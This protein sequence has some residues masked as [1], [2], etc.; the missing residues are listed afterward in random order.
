VCCSSAL[1]PPSCC[2]HESSPLHVP[3]RSLFKPRHATPR[4]E[5]I[6][7]S[8]V[9]SPIE[10]EDKILR[11]VGKLVHTDVDLAFYHLPSLPPSLP[12]CTC[13][14]GAHRAN[15]RDRRGID[16]RQESSLDSIESKSRLP[17]RERERSEER[18]GEDRKGGE[19]RG[20][21]LSNI[22]LRV[23]EPH[24]VDPKN[25]QQILRDKI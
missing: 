23:L 9:H 12:L 19:R 1:S 25:I 3:S 21:D 16:R 11:A 22:L 2:N 6:D 15:D 20:G 5:S 4:H 14:L 17:V 7:K 24:S 13:T 18:R 8:L 10:Y